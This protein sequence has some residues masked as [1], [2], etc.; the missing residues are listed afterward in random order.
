M[1]GNCIKKAKDA[2]TYFADFGDP[3]LNFGEDL[4]VSCS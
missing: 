4:I 3:V 1:Q 2:S